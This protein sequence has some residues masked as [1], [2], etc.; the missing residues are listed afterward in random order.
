MIVE[1]GMGADIATAV[2]RGL[3]ALVVHGPFSAAFG[4]RLDTKR[5][6]GQSYVFTSFHFPSLSCHLRR[7]I[8]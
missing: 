7:A 8:K 2:C 6:G 1:P 4:V 5:Q 3:L